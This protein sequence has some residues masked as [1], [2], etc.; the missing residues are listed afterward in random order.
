MD[1]S[2]NSC[3]KLGFVEELIKINAGISA[4]IAKTRKKE[5][6]ILIMNGVK[7][8]NELKLPRG[9]QLSNITA[10]F[11]GVSCQIIRKEMKKQFYYGVPIV[12][13]ENDIVLSEFTKLKNIE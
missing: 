5:K 6:V 1:I 3:E 7:N 8:L 2:K 10:Q 13:V 9:W 11:D 12:L 4:R